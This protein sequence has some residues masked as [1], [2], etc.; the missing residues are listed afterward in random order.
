M[1]RR[2]SLGLA[3]SVALHVA[4]VCVWVGWTAF[5]DA[6]PGAVDI[7]VVGMRV[8][9][10]K[11]LPLGAPAAGARPAPA[12][13]RV[14]APAST[15]KDGTLASR[16]EPAPAR[17]GGDVDGDEGGVPRVNDVRALGPAGARLTVLLRLDRLKGTP[18]AEPVDRLLM[19]M[20]DRR[21]LLEGTGLGLYDDFDAL[22]VSTPNPLDPTVTFLAAHHHLADAKLRAAIDR[23]ARATGRVIAWRT[24]DRRP[25]GERRATSA[26]A[27]PPGARDER[28]IVLPAP[29]LVVVTPPAYRKLLLEHGRPPT[30]ADGGVA[31]VASSAR[32]GGADAGAPPPTA[33]SWS[34]LLR[35]IDAEDGLLP[36]NAMAMVTAADLLKPGTTS[37]MGV[38]LDVPRE[39]AAVLGGVPEPFVEVTGTYADE[40][41]ARRVEVTWPALQRKLRSN[42]YVVLGGLSAIVARATLTREGLSVVLRVT[43]TP[44]EA[45]RLLQMT[46]AALGG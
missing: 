28:I 21:D 7:D 22:L 41:Q 13:A 8:D 29:G 42:A 5:R 15:E 23:G 2:W 43:T 14:H 45:Q 10:V 19:R 26:A 27:P 40:A 38:D 24:E 9:E 16:D 33:P 34:A 20:P 44:D 37:W 3:L 35:R 12:R 30:A 11:D 46:T 31:S 36:P 39:L 1:V 32:D 18:F 17:A 25:W 6:A 4:V